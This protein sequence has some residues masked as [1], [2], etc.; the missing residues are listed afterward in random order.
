MKEIKDDINRWGNIPHSWKGRMNIVKM[1]ILPFNLQIQ[2]NPYQITNGIFH[3]T[4]TKNFII[5]IE[6]LLLLLLSHFSHVQ[7]YAIPE[8]AAHQAPPSLGFSRKEHWS[9]LP[10]ILKTP[11]SQSSLQKEEWSWR[12]QTFLTSD[13]TTKLQSSRQYGTDTKTEI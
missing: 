3:R 2:C 8:M 5:H 7:L 12:N 11:N 1:T 4:R 13:Y 10:D 9:G 6:T